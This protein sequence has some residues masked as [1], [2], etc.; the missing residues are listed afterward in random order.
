MDVML[1]THSLISSLH[2]ADLLRD[3]TDVCVPLSLPSMKCTAGSEPGV[4]LADLR[5]FVIE[6]PQ[7]NTLR[8]P[9]GELTCPSHLPW[10]CH[11]GVA[12]RLLV[13]VPWHTQSPLSPI[14]VADAQAVLLGCSSSSHICLP[15]LLRMPFPHGDYMCFPS[16]EGHVQGQP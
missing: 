9:S 12:A 6:M 10:L 1:Q 3:E 4:R 11:H 14:R 7:R 16:N 15:G 2:G 8:S 5:G 13:G